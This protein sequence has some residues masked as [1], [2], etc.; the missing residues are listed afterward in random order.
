MAHQ[1]ETDWKTSLNIQSWVLC[2]A[3][4][5][6]VVDFKILQLRLEG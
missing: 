2:Q 3:Q 4:Y 5:Y 1:N 6:R